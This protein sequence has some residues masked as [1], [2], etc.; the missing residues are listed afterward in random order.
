MISIEDFSKVEMKIGEI[1]SAER[2]PETDR[3]L[4]LEVDFGEEENRQVVSGIAE[5]FEDPQEL[6]GVK[7]SFVT[8]LEPRKIRGLASEAMIMAAHTENGEFSLLEPSDKNISAGTKL[9]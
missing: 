9:N 7:C 4:R 8:N 6:V 5:Y 1:I 3:L 2:V